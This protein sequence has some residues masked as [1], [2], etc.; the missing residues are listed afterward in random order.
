MR[1][2]IMWCLIAQV[3]LGQVFSGGG[4][5]GG[6]GGGSVGPST[7]TSLGA[8]IMSYPPSNPA[9]PTAVSASDPLVTNGPYLPTSGGTVTNVIDMGN[10]KITSVTTPTSPLDASNK[11]Y[12]DSL[13][14]FLPLSGGQITAGASIPLT[15]QGTGESGLKL[16]NKTAYATDARYS[17]FFYQSADLNGFLGN[18][19]AQL[20][21][22]SGNFVQ[23][24]QKLYLDMGLDTQGTAIS[25]GSIT[26]T[27]ITDSGL[28]AT[29]VPYAS[30][31]G[32]LADSANVTFDGVSLSVMD[33]VSPSQVANMHYVDTHGGGGPSLPITG[34]T[35]TGPVTA[36]AITDSGLTAP[37]FP[38]KSAGGPMADS[39][40]VTFDGVSLS[41]TDPVSTSHVASKHYVDAATTGGPF[42]P[43]SGGTMTGVL[44]VNN[45]IAVG[46]GTQSL[47]F[48]DNGYCLWQ[49]DLTGH[50]YQLFLRNASLGYATVW[51]VYGNGDMMCAGSL[52]VQNQNP[53]L[54]FFQSTTDSTAITA[55]SATTFDVSS[56]VANSGD[57]NVIG[58][59]IHG[60]VS[61]IQSG[62][63]SPGTDTMSVLVGAVPFSF[64]AVTLTALQTDQPWRMQ[65]DIEDRTTG[66]TG[67]ARW[68]GRLSFSV[69][70][71]ETAVI[72]GG[73]VSGVDWTGSPL[74]AVQNT[75]SLTGNSITVQ[76]MNL[77]KVH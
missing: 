56:T 46:P 28:T 19:G 38:Y 50:G 11:A 69:A 3:A 21:K 68:S 34:G 40:N 55:N 58:A 14:P 18:A 47:F 29:R 1:Y 41:V 48:V 36:T 54:C 64:P 67:T 32:L 13:G 63:A 57:L 76:K 43:K 33:P 5:A 44:T 59:A 75:F 16:W 51:G 66:A 22:L 53:A 7:V 77:Q 71:V 62:A 73:A 23:I 37:R 27:S 4:Q 31:G 42:L 20:M 2:L 39:A 30:T 35:V 12:V 65:F 70:G 74:V 72:A 25:A 26:G 8:V 49:T 6:G 24:N 9:Q 60:E 61:G 52:T 17:L 10:H 45:S 15:L